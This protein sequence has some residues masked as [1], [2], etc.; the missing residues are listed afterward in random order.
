MALH[1]S[2]IAPDRTV[3]DSNAEEVILPSSTGQLG[4]LRGHAP[5]LTALD[6]GVMR[7][8][9]DKDWTPIV[10]MGGFAEVEN[11]EL[12]ILVN[13]AEDVL[14]LTNKKHKKN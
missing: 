6:I 2:I 7:V 4:I 1:I 8:R 5:L 12:T 3:W 13:G 9:T 14:L 10:L 11:D